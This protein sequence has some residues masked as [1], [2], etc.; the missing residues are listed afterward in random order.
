M[1]S[2]DY[3]V[4]LL[5]ENIKKCQDLH[6]MAHKETN[7]CEQRMK[8]L[9]A[10][11][12]SSVLLDECSINEIKTLLR[13]YD[14]ELYTAGY[15]F[16]LPGID[17]QLHRETDVEKIKGLVIMFNKVRDFHN[18]PPINIDDVLEFKRT[19]KITNTKTPIKVFGSDHTFVE[20]MNKVIGC[21][22]AE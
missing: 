14:P 21:C 2:I 4:D 17:N 12:D 9:L 19:G 3:N 1:E 6:I 10:M 15:K 13:D 5:I 16:G 22:A 8:S 18:Y 20:K 11:C 7:K